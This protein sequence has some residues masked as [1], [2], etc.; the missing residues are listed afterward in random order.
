VWFIDIN[1]EALMPYKSQTNAVLQIRHK[2]FL[3]FV[4]HF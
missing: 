1:E 4:A 2:G 3:L